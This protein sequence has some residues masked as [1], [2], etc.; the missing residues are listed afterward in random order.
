MKKIYCVSV[1]SNKVFGGSGEWHFLASRLAEAVA[2]AERKLRKSPVTF[3]GWFVKRAHE[4]GVLADESLGK[5]DAP[6]TRSSE[7][8][9]PS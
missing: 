6:R 7:P 4:V 2:K 5:L 9:E 1:S 3:K 8:P